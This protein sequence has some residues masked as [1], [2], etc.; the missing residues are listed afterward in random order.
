MLA[1]TVRSLAVALAMLGAAVTETVGPIAGFA[2]GLAAAYLVNP[3]PAR[4]DGSCTPVQ[5]WICGLNGV[6]YNNK[7]YV[8]TQ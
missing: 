1:R 3:Q 7:R 8:T 2:V 5:G 4:C 6:N